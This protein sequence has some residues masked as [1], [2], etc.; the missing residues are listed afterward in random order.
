MSYIR[1]FGKCVTRIRSDFSKVV[2]KCGI[3]TLGA[4]KYNTAYVISQYTVNSNRVSYQR[5]VTSKRSSSK[6]DW[7]CSNTGLCFVS[8]GLLSFFGLK[9]DDS[10]KEPELITT[11]KRGILLTQVISTGFEVVYTVYHDHKNSL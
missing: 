6:N 2:G 8:V 11:I 4:V 5:N 1:N 3:C 7:Q 9:N 10:E